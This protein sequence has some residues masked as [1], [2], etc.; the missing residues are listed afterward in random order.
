MN[1]E[2]LLQPIQTRLWPTTLYNGILTPM[3]LGIVLARTQETQREVVE[4]KQY[5]HTRSSTNINHN[6]LRPHHSYSHNYLI[7]GCTT[8]LPTRIVQR[9]Y[10][11]YENSNLMCTQVLALWTTISLFLS[12]F[13]SQTHSLTSVQE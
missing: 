6:F 5:N 13:L 1:K 4:G 3:M 7:K 12:F 11:S 9:D 2:I 10:N 8:R